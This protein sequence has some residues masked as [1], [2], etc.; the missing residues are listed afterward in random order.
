MIVLLF[1]CHIRNCHIRIACHELCKSI[2]SLIKSGVGGKQGAVERGAGFAQAGLRSTC[3]NHK[4]GSRTSAAAAAEVRGFLHG[5]VC[6]GQLV[7]PCAACA[8]ACAWT[9]HAHCVAHAPDGHGRRRRAHGPAE[10]EAPTSRASLQGVPPRASAHPKDGPAVSPRV[11]RVCVCSQRSA[12]SGERSASSSGVRPCVSP[13]PSAPTVLQ[14]RGSMCRGSAQATESAW[15]VGLGC[16][17]WVDWIGLRG[18]STR[19]Q[20]THPKISANQAG[21]WKRGSR[22]RRSLRLYLSERRAGCPAHHTFHVVTMS[23]RRP[24]ERHAGIH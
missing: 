6:A 18:G 24:P 21:A 3:G 7:H 19:R 14:Y 11:S 5:G 2:E 8:A 22:T 10:V 16:P 12:V 1:V 9:W 23:H 20:T 17:S 13:P 4:A 15:A